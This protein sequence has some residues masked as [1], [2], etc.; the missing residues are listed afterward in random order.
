MNLDGIQPSVHRN[1]SS[2]MKAQRSANTIGGLRDTPQHRCPA[3]WHFNDALKLHPWPVCPGDHVFLTGHRANMVRTKP[4][5][6]SER[7][8]QRW[9][10]VLAVGAG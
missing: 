4:V 8:Q 3:G 9:S 2:Q 6:R 7:R 1:A 5:T 10:R